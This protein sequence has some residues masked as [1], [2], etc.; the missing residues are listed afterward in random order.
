[1]L[2]VG[3]AV[4]DAVGVRLARGDGDLETLARGDPTV[5]DPACSVPSPRLSRIT[6][7]M[8]I[9]ATAPTAA[10]SARASET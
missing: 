6:T 7:A 10:P 8:T 4:G 1:V 9:R 3:L 2:D 5:G